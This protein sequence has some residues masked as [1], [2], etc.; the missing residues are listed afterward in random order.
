V[1][2]LWSNRD[3]RRL[4]IGETVSLI[5]SEVRELAL[6]LT[7]ILVLHADAADLGLLAAA[8]F[9]P[10]LLFTLP[11]GALADR[12]RRRP[13]LILANVGRAMAIGSI[14]VLAAIGMLTMP[15]LFVAA[16]AVGALT[17]LFDVTY[18]SYV[19]VVVDR[20]QLIEANSRLQASASASAIGGPG[21]GGLLIQ[22][23]TAPVALVI[24]ALSYVVS[25]LN[26]ALIRDPEQPPAPDPATRGMITE[27]R[28]G[29]GMLFRHRSLRALAGVAGTYNLFSQWIV[30]LFVL[31]AVEELGLS[32]GLIGAIL[33][34]GAVGALIGAALAGIAA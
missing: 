23:L 32:S 28:D 22:F 4:W 7:A 30:V 10:F 3:F 5:A 14:P 25:A 13:M 33:A 18:I 19:P 17:V 1:T 29:F 16:F 31:F 9:A 24:D 12:R 26:L 20:D 2:T 34:S 15:A 27:V 21:I 6:P 8:R 11:I